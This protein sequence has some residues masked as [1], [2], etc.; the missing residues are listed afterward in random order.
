MAIQVDGILFDTLSADPGTP[1]EGQVWYNTTT[2]LFGIYRNGAAS[3]FSDASALGAHTG[4]TSNPHTTTLEQ[5]RTAGATFAGAINMGGFA[6]TNVGTGTTSTD[7]AQRQ[8]VTDQINSKV[9]GL[10]WQDPVINSLATPPVS[11]VSGDRY[12]IIATATGAWAAKE[13]QIA[14]WG[15]A[16]WA[17]TVATE[18]FI[19]RDMTANTY[20][21][22]DG[23]AWGNLGNAVD[24]NSL[25]NL[26]I[27]DVH[28]Q[29]L[30]LSGG[31]SMTGALNMG[32]NNI[33]NVGT[34]GG[35]TMSQVTPSAQVI[36]AGA[37]GVATSLNRSDHVHALSAAAPTALAIGSAQA[38]GT[39][40]SV[41]AA[42]HVHA[43]PGFASPAAQTIGAG[44]AGASASVPRADHVHA[45]SAGSPTA[46]TA[47][48]TQLT[49]TAT[50]VA[51]SDHVHATPTAAAIAITDATNGAGASASFAAADHTHSHGQRGGGTTAAPLHSLAS[52]SAPGFLPQSNMVATVNPAVSNDGT[53]GYSVG[54]HWY[55][56][57]AQTVW[58]AISV[59]TGAAVWKELTNTSG[60]LATKSGKM[61][62]ASFAGSPKKATVTFTTPFVDANY[63]V[64]VSPVISVSGSSYAPA[65]ESQLAGS[66]VINMAAGS[67]GSLVSA[68][69]VAVK[70]G[71]SV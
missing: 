42:D 71:E 70:T 35:I 66:F 23:T 47:G 55:N 48:G 59:A 29:Y 58:T 61:L 57:T 40:T 53:Q 49:G 60:V 22:F 17:Y 45:M 33:T 68:N 34:V 16:A 51:A 69:W 1:V 38:T 11:P 27:G 24:H 5:A 2:K 65:I 54:S 41:A 36:G 63:S 15:G 43:M 30:P 13:N 31:R 4:S 21:V 39:S 50:T 14:Q 67:I 64:T 62:A 9:A 7:T 37:A 19:V 18:G 20:V 28:T 56:T 52:A 12:R 6:I 8:W 46:L 26:G 25:L 10:D 44:A 32:T 3:T